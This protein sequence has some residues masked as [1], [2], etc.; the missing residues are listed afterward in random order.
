[1]SLSGFVMT[2]R[3]T[4]F[5][6]IQIT[7]GRIYCDDVKT[8]CQILINCLSGRFMGIDSMFKFAKLIQFVLL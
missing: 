5:V 2:D 7:G 8:V 3:I 4:E 6:Y 1:M